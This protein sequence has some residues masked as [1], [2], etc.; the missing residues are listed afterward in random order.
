MAYCTVDDVQPYI[1]HFTIDSTSQPTKSEV[2]QMCDHVSTGVIDPIIRDVVDLPLTD[3]VGLAYLKLGAIYYVVANVYKSIEGS[4]EL[5]ADYNQRFLDFL[6]MIKTNNSLLIKP[7][8][9]YPK[10]SGTTRRDPKYTTDFDTD[11]W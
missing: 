1:A 2:S 3:T 7:N 11:I 9:D 5:I 6:A 8:D 10:T 4:P